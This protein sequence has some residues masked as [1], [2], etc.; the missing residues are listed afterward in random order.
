[1]DL[2]T[3]LANARA[4]LDA[5]IAERKTAQDA[6][7]A[8][9]QRAEESGDVTLEDTDAAIARRNAADAA[10]DSARAKVAEVEAEVE[11]DAEIAKLE[12]QVRS[13]GD[14]PAYDR[15]VRTG[16]EPRTYTRES[17]P[18]GQGFMAD[19]LRGTMSND[20]LARG[21][22][23]RH[24]AEEQVER[25]QYLDR[26]VGTSAF[27]GLTV[28]Q[29]LVEEFAEIAKAGRPF[30]DICRAHDLPP[31]GMTVEIGR[32]TTATNVDVQ[33]AQ[34]DAAAETNYDDTLLSVPVQSAAGQQTLSQQAVR[35]S[36]GAY[37]ITIEDLI[38]EYHQDLDSKLIT[39]ATTGLSAVATSVAYTDA[40]PTVVELY[41]KF[42]ASSAGVSSALLNKMRARDLV[43]VM[44]SRRWFWL[45]SALSDQRPLIGQPGIGSLN[46]G[47]NYAEAYG[48]GFAGLLP[49]GQPVVL[50]D[51]IAINLGAGTNEDEIYTVARS[52]CHLWE[53]PQAPL[54]IETQ[55]TKAANLQVLV[56]V[57][58]FYAY[59]FGRRPHARKIAGTGLVTPSF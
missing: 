34:G 49:N 40:S 19:F 11:R 30:A 59:T 2:N 22:L 31:T 1:M 24:M 13:T 10:V 25:G 41:P 37:D 45:N 26:A 51:N 15:Q 5:K 33:A 8:L 32:G 6:L 9:R 4:V 50:D 58:G 53:D 18:K 39:Q 44:H 23:E 3:M 29:Y 48:M 12:Q 27:A 14:R 20:F 43:H 17:D 42:A 56:V 38:G 35:R 46:A 21:R 55:E 52:E 28:P 36:L 16:A 47:E 7:M 57:F 54:F